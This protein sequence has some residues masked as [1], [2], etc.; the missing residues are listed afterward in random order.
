V[1]TAVLQYDCK[2][3]VADLVPGSSTHLDF[4]MNPVPKG[5]LMMCKIMRERSGKTTVETSEGD[6][7]K[8]TLKTS[9]GVVDQTTLETSEGDVD[10]TTLKTSEGFVDKTTLETSEED[11][12]QTTLETSEEDVGQTTLGTSEE[13]VG[14]LHSKRVKKMLVNYTRSE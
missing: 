11:V 8:T 10:K 7:D 13:D 9:E 3:Q 14:K 2:F 6:V 1:K 12:R 4:L 5:T